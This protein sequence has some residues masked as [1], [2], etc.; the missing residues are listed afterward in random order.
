MLFIDYSSAFNTIIPLKLDTKLKSLGLNSSLCNWILDFL[1]ERR[2]V[3]KMGT[4]TS[5]PL[6]LSTGAPQGCVLSPLLY[7]L[8]THDCVASFNTNQVIKFADDTTVIG[9][10]TNDDETAYRREVEILELWC[11]ENNLALNV[12]KTKELIIDYRRPPRAHSPIQIGGTAVERV[13]EF[14]FLGVH[15]TEDL[16]WAVQTERVVKKAQQRLYF[17][18]KLKKAGMGPNVLRAFYRGTTESI[19]TGCFTAWYGG[20]T[21]LNRKALQRVVKTA[22]RISGCNLPP[23]QVLF[24]ERCVSKARGIIKDKT[25]PNHSLF[26]MLPHGKRLGSLAAT[27][28]RMQKSFFPRTVRLLNELSKTKKT[29][30]KRKR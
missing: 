26:R 15:I 12:D 1:T 30:S 25:H 4:M 2:Q 13:K 19:L 23:I 3:V 21:D 11:Q 24:D 20:C 17:L 27:S 16:T 22:E 6:T 7:S 29:Q 10:I 18:R 8:Y 14:K 9:L 28:N 5:A